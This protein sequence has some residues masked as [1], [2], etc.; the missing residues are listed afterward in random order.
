MKFSANAHC[1]WI[2][3]AQ[4]MSQKIK[5]NLND[6]IHTTILKEGRLNLVN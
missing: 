4:E 1:K 5:K 6:A 2:F 3:G